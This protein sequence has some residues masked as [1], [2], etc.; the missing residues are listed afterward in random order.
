MET[1]VFL[2]AIYIWVVIINFAVMCL[3]WRGT[4]VKRYRQL[5]QVWGIGI[6]TLI[7]GALT[8]KLGPFGR[9]IGFSAAFPF[10]LLISA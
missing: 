3:L 6:L 10:Y 5:M 9:L 7:A 4:G 8:A 1:L 2:L